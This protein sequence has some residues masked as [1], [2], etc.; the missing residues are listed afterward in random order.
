M[1]ENRTPID[2]IIRAISKGEVVSSLQQDDII[3]SN[4]PRAADTTLEDVGVIIGVGKERV[5]QIEARAIRKLKHPRRSR[6]LHTL[7]YEL[8]NSSI[9]HDIESRPSDTS[10]IEY[11]SYIKSCGN[12]EFMEDL[13]KNCTKLPAYYCDHMGYTIHVSW[14][15]I[16]GRKGQEIV[17][18]TEKGH[19]RLEVLKNDSTG[20]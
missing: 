6:K 20:R 12:V 3:L 19:K 13:K 7:L 2:Y 9:N 4:Q 18:I 11:L 10:V 5:R 1:L 15:F 17:F 8:S 16:R 14:P